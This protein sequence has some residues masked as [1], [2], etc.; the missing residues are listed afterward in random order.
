MQYSGFFFD[1]SKRLSMNFHRYARRAMIYVWCG[2]RQLIVR[3]EIADKIQ[4]TIATHKRLIINRQIRFN[5][6][7]PFC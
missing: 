2:H 5:T 4:L 1:I 3:L 7:S 6:K